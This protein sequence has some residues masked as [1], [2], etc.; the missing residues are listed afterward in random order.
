M[1]ISVSP[2]RAAGM[3]PI[4]TVGSPTLTMP[5]TCAPSQDTCLR[6]Y[7]ATSQLRDVRS[8]EPNADAGQSF[9]LYPGTGVNAATSARNSSSEPV[10]NRQK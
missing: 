4:F 10:P 1:Q 5:P 8:Y 3:K 2:T 9:G 7:A 6:T